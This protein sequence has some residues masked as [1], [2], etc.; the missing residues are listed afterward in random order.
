MGTTD[1]EQL[2]LYA[3][4]TRVL[5]LIR[6]THSLAAI[7]EGTIIGPVWEVHIVNIIDG[8]G[9]EVAIPSIANPTDTSYVVISR[10]TERFVNVVS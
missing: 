3:V 5:D 2:L 1:G 8:H 9:I 7:P 4:N 10:E 6:K